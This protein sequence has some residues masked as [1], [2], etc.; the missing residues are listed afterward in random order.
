MHIS[1]SFKPYQRHVFWQIFV[2]AVLFLI[3]GNVI[4]YVIDTQHAFRD[5]QTQLKQLAVNVADRIP[6][7][8]HEQITSSEQMESLEYNA[9]EK[10]LQIIAAANPS[11]DDIYTLRQTVTPN[12][13]SFV[14]SAAETEDRDG[15]N[16]IDESEEKAYVGQLYD[17]GQAPEMVAALVAPS[18]DTQI[19]Y[20]QWGAWLS[21]Y[22]PL[23]DGDGAVVGIV[24]VD[25]SAD[26][27]WGQYRET[28]RSIVIID[29]ILVPLLIFFAYIVSRRL[30]RPFRILANGMNHV[31]HG[32]ID[33]RLPVHGKGEEAVFERL[34]NNMLEMFKIIESKGA[35]KH[36]DER[37]DKD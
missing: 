13:F 1:D 18:A 24:G 25:M 5:F 6:V 11:I 4:M 10:E 34:F 12:I 7:D 19:T 20:D 27:I 26:V 22:S 16:K 9:I 36:R 8:V 35:A 2:L 29:S 21:G 33:Y 31:A 3:V 15:D 37:T 32:D 23:T 30:S 28:F 17:T 14:V